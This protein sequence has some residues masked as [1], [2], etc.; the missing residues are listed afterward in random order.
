MKKTH[1]QYLRRAV[2]VSVN[3]RASDSIRQLLQS[4]RVGKT[5]VYG[6]IRDIVTDERFFLVTEADDFWRKY[7]REVIARFIDTFRPEDWTDTDTIDARREAFLNRWFADHIFTLSE[8]EKDKKLASLVEETSD[9]E[10]DAEALDELLMGDMGKGKIYDCTRGTS[11]DDLDNLPQDL[12]AY[13]ADVVGRTHGRGAAPETSSEVTFLRSIDPAIVEMAKKIGRAGE[14]TSETTGGRF[15]RSSKSDIMGITTGNDL[16]CVMP[17][18]LALLGDRATENV[19]LEKFVQKRLQVFASASHS[20]KKEKLQKGPI[21]MCVDTSGSMSGNPETMAKTV[22]LAV[23][24]V[25]QRE[26]RPLI[27]I[28]YSHTLSFFV[29]QNL[30]RQKKELMKFLSR[31]YSGGNDENLL[32][33]F[34]FRRLP[35]MPKY[36]AV[37]ER[38]EGAD[39]LVI[40]DFIWGWL[41]E[42]V[43]ELLEESRKKGMQVFAVS[44]NPVVATAEFNPEEYMADDGYSF[45][46]KSDHRYTYDAEEGL[47][48]V[49]TSA[50]VTTRFKKRRHPFLQASMHISRNTYTDIH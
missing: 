49:D 12:Q 40:S 42:D 23:A 19:F 30:K 45:F 36:R 21:F 26:K 34:I 46:N 11:E 14:K 48:C 4:Q 20:E 35:Q 10:E 47:K 43:M 37:A 8:A 18:E 9:S 13:A 28:N 22:A 31:S 17:A 3:L 24:I 39:M 27:L 15:L 1:L 25:A 41:K 38:F 2:S 32:F 44:T 16:N 50:P 6:L 5:P 7:S 29:L 33:D